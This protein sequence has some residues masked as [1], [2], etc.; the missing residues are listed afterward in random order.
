MSTSKLNEELHNQIESTMNKAFFDLL[1]ENIKKD[2]ID[3]EWLTRLF[4]EIR[5]RFTRLLKKNSR[6]WIEINENMNDELFTQMIKNNVFDVNSF[7]GLV[8]YS[9]LL[10]LKLGAP[11]RD[12]TTGVRQEQ[13]NKL[14]ETTQDFT[15]IIPI[16]IKNIHECIDEIYQDIRDVP[17]HLTDHLQSNSSTV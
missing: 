9:F 4:I 7:I 6:L 5:D 10:C 11:V 12:K 1:K 16:Y 15:E 3:Y 13:V 14:I 2:P 17:K 8:N